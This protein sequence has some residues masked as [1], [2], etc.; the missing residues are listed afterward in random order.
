MKIDSE[1]LGEGGL[2][3]EIRSSTSDCIR[4]IQESWEGA[5]RV[6][7]C[8]KYFAVETCTVLVH[9]E[10]LLDPENAMH[11]LQRY[12]DFETVAVAASIV[13]AATSF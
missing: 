13:A 9:R 8:H 5:V 2:F 6:G 4:G 1:P 3:P 10:S 11:A 12:F 7:R